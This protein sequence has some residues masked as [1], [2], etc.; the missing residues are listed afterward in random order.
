MLRK[1]VPAIIILLTTGVVA[2]NAAITFVYPAPKSWVKRADYLILKLNDPAIT[3]V[4]IT[5]N[6]EASGIMPIGTPEYRKAFRDFIILQALWDKGKNDVSVEA[7]SGDKRIETA[8]NDVWFNP[9]G[10]EPAPPE[11]QPNR[12]HTPENEKLCAPCHSMNPTPAQLAAGPGKGNPCFGCH[13]KMMN[14]TFVH[15]P[16]GTYSCTYCHTGDRKFKYAVPK[17]DAALCN[18][19]HSDKG[20]E[21]TKR[22]FVHGPIAAGL[23]EVCHDSHGSPYPAQLLMPI[24]DLCLSCHEDVGKGYH[25]TR[26]TSGAPHPLTWKSDPSKPS[27]GREMSCISCHNPHSGDVRYFFVNNAEDRLLLCQMCHNK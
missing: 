23:C 13:K 4:R 2:A 21:F 14:S 7:F 12:L 18:E 8:V 27:S 1:I 24:N 9:G 20:D 25:V 5:L 17:R 19:C 16:A 10:K 22:K 15:G 3:G 26:T 6:G 11:Y